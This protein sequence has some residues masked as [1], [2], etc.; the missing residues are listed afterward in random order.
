VII[1]NHYAEAVIG[2]CLAAITSGK[3]R[4]EVEVILVDNPSDPAA[5]MAIPADLG[6]KRIAAPRDT[7]LRHTCSSSIRTSSSSPPR[8]KPC[9]RPWNLI[10]PRAPLPGDL[11]SRMG[12]SSRRAG[13]FRR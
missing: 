6:L 10:L 4:L 9:T 7:L 5:A 3:G 8:F 2:D 11:P 12:R 1:V 13:G